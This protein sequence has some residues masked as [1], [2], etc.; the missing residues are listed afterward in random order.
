MQPNLLRRSFAALVGMLGI[1]SFQG[2][3]ASAEPQPSSPAAGRRKRIRRSAAEVL[4]A[5]VLLGVV[6]ALLV[7]KHLEPCDCPTDAGAAATCRHYRIFGHD[8]CV[9][10]ATRHLLGR[11]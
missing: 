11:R 5:L 8:V 2:R 4:L 7:P 6:A 1:S 9:S 10:C 3:P